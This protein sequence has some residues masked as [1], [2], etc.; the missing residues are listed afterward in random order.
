MNVLGRLEA[1]HG[2]S[3]T[4]LDYLNLAVRNYHDSGNVLVMCVPLSVLA[5]L[6]QELGRA[7]QAATISGYS[8]NPF[9]AA[10]L[11]EIGSG[12][13]HLREALGETPFESLARKGETITTAEIVAYAYYEIDQARA[14]SNTRDS[15]RDRGDE[16]GRLDERRGKNDRPH[17]IASAHFIW[18]SSPR[19][20]DM[21]RWRSGE[22]PVCGLI[23]VCGLS[24]TPASRRA[25][26]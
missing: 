22:L 5:M 17:G 11:P 18:P 8:V 20:V 23:A 12:V 15:R 25:P 13:A 1:Q 10:W 26:Q 19:N 3:L 4:A 9:T 21:A 24:S 6:L 14:D 16:D 2:D 7:E